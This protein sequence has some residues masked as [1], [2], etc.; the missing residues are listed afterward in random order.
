MLLDIHFES[1]S[2]FKSFYHA[3]IIPAKHILQQ[4]VQVLFKVFLQ[5]KK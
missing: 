1:V 5:S 3:V 4:T 2:L